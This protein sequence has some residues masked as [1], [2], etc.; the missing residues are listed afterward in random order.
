VLHKY[1]FILEDLHVIQKE[2]PVTEKNA[3]KSRKGIYKLQD[4]FFKFWFKYVLPNKGNVEA[5]RIDLVKQKMKA[6]WA[7]FVAENYENLAQNLT[8]EHEERFF[9]M[10]KVGRWWDKNEEIDIV[11][12]NEDEKKALFGEAKWSNR[13]VGVDVYENLKRKTYLVEW[14]RGE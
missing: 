2:V 8:R 10:D 6:D 7:S 4:Q 11:A 3:L 13:P 12:L 14:N 9:P 5:G 1:L